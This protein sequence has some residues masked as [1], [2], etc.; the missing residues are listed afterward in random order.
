[1]IATTYKCDL[2][3]KEVSYPEG[4]YHLTFSGDGAIGFVWLDD[5][6]GMRHQSAIKIQRD[7]TIVCCE[8]AKG[9]R[10]AVAHLP[11]ARHE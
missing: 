3:K 5:T 6:S 4:G 11:A 7:E 1:M 10:Y 2:C 8:C 9:L